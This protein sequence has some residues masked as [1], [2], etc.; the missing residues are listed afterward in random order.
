M[1]EGLLISQ[2]VI[3]V[4][5]NRALYTWGRLVGEDL[6]CVAGLS[7]LGLNKLGRACLGG[8]SA[9]GMSIFLHRL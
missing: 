5:C 8:P 6:F 4:W 2:Q 1:G 7:T 3:V 9:L